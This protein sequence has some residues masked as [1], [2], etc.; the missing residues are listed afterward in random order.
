M[1]CNLS[2]VGWN[3]SINI[4]ELSKS[5]WG[6]GERRAFSK[7]CCL[8]HALVLT[9]L[10]VPSCNTL[11]AKFLFQGCPALNPTS[12]IAA[13]VRISTWKVQQIGA[14]CPCWAVVTN[15][16]RQERTRA[17]KQ[18]SELLCPCQDCR[19]AQDW[20]GQGC[21][22]SQHSQEDVTPHLLCRLAASAPPLF[23]EEPGTGNYKPA[24]TLANLLSHYVP[25][26]AL[27]MSNGVVK[28][29]TGHSAFK[30]QEQF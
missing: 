25:W 21:L 15:G 16:S 9:M 5:S 28:S 23:P 18:P 22:G 4:N 30:A 3:N 8:S 11:R 19:T 17:S 2:Q 7:S 27:S 14:R 12:I 29:D 6:H 13:P 10:F 1:G 20:Q 26:S 24:H